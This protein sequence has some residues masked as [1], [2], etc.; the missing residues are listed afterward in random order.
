MNLGQ[1]VSV[2]LKSAQVF[3]YATQLVPLVT[4]FG[5]VTPVAAG[6]NAAQSVS[7]VPAK[8]VQALSLQA[9]VA[10]AADVL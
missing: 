1:V 8:S 5:V 3:G 4:Q 2:P 7:D 9:V 10:V 6:I